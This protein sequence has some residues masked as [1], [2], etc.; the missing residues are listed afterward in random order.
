MGVADAM[1]YLKSFV[2]C[3]EFSC[4]LEDV[5]QE[6]LVLRPQEAASLCVETSVPEWRCLWFK[7]ICVCERCM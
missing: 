6:G 4:S 3:L 1:E 7:V 2:S 5:G